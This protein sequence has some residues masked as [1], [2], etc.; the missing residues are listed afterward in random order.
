MA[1][2][3]IGVPAPPAADPTN[4]GEVRNTSITRIV[5]IPGRLDPAGYACFAFHPQASAACQPSSSRTRTERGRD[6]DDRRRIPAVP[7][8]RGRVGRE[9]RRRSGERHPTGLPG[10]A[11]R[12]CRV[13]L[14]DLL[15]P[16]AMARP[17]QP[18]RGRRAAD[19]DG[20]LLPGDASTP[21][22][23]RSSARPGWRRSV[24]V[25]A[26]R[27]ESLCA[28][29]HPGDGAGQRDGAGAQPA[30]GH[31]H[32]GG[33]HAASPGPRRLA[34]RVGRAS[35]TPGGHLGGGPRAG[36][37]DRRGR[38]VGAALRPPRAARSVGLRR[39]ASAASASSGCSSIQESIGWFGWLDV[40]P[41]DVV[42]LVWFAAAVALVVT[43]LVLGGRRDRMVVIGVLLLAVVVMLR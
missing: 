24:A 8:P 9:P 37:L 4:L 16:G 41:P 15:A 21:V 35:R 22:R 28:N 11:G 32:H 20:D 17:A 31:R 30:A 1:Q 39:T 26:R 33:A 3:D 43:A 5:E 12:L 38:G 40:R 2:F 6:R 13:A 14:A 34:R 10:G 29:G 23:S 25:Y 42:N 18:R 27:P 19:P 7:L 36:G